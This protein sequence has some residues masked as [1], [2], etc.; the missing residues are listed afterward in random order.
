[1]IKLQ[2]TVIPLFEGGKEKLFACRQSED[3]NERASGGNHPLASASA[4]LAKSFWMDFGG[5]VRL[6]P[7]FRRA[8]IN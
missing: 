8:D 1:M 2:I 4:R 6:G 7:I 3:E 5:G